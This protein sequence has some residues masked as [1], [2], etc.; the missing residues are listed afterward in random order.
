GLG[1]SR[2]GRFCLRLLGLNRSSI[3][4]LG[5]AAAGPLDFRHAHHGEV[6][7]MTVLDAAACLGLVLEHDDL[8]AASGADDLG[9]ALGA[10]DD[11]RSN[12]GLVAV[13]HEQYTADVDPGTGLSGKLIQL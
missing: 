4:F 7:T 3:R 12:Q 1:F 8:V 13:G 11:W 5:G 9:G 2:L 10:L 6:L